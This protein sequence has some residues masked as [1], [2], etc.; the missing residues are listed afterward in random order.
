MDFRCL[1]ILKLEE[2]RRINSKA[3]LTG[4]TKVVTQRRE[5]T[6]SFHTQNP[7]CMEARTPLL[8]PTP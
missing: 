7:L 5:S 4:M 1:D 3:P 8:L 2:F 6:S